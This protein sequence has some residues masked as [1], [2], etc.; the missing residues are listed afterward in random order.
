LQYPQ[1]GHAPWKR[2][3]PFFH[4]PGLVK[5]EQDIVEVLL[6]PFNDRRYNQDLGTL[7]EQV[8][9]GAPCLPDGRR[10][11]FSVQ[12][13]EMVRPILDVQKRRAS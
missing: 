4:L 2:L 5:Q 7:C 1:T 8:N 6:R 10:L 13:N 3:A 9:A 11:H 12:V